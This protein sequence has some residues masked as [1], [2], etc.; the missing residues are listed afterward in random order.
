[1]RVVRCL[2]IEEYL[3]R[4]EKR[5]NEKLKRGTSLSNIPHAAN[6]SGF[7]HIILVK[8]LIIKYSA[9]ADNNY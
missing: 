3:K 8:K 6:A 2:Y 5:N 1:M 7:L 9:T 4:V